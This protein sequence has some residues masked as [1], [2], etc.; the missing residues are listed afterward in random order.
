MRTYIPGTAVWIR[1]Y[2]LY[3]CKAFLLHVHIR[4]PTLGGQGDAIM[5]SR[6]RKRCHRLKRR[7]GAAQLKTR[8]RTSCIRTKYIPGARYQVIRTCSYKLT[9][10]R[11]R[12]AKKQTLPC[13][14]KTH[15]LISAPGIETKWI[16]TTKHTA[17]RYRNNASK[18]PRPP[19]IL[20]TWY[21]L[22]WRRLAT[23][24]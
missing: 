9:R 7:E 19:Y 23:T 18:R 8:C 14:G 21:R 10:T 24:P 2:K 17:Q 3:A 22:C 5:A 1:P 4:Q 20:H 15:L 16:H 12:P 6:R 13:D 11:I